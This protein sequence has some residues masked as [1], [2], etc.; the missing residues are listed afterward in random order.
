M[1][2]NLLRLSG[3]T[4][5]TRKLNTYSSAEHLKIIILTAWSVWI[6]RNNK[7]FSN[8]QATVEGWR[9]RYKQ[10]LRLFCDSNEKIAAPTIQRV[11][12]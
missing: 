11:A 4:S 6:I 10:E 2:K 8:Q 7:K 3:K 1:R 5:T 9:I 12:K